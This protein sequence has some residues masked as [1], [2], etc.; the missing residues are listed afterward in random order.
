VEFV[1]QTNIKIAPRRRWELVNENILGIPRNV[2]RV[3][4]RPTRWAHTN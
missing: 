1:H 3:V 2:N 4:T